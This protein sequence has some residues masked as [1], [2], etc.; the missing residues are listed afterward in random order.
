MSLALADGL[1]TTGPAGKSYQYVFNFV[2]LEPVKFTGKLQ[3]YHKESLQTPIPVP[4]LLTSTFADICPLSLPM[5]MHT[6]SQMQ[7]LLS[8]RTCSCLL[9]LL[10]R[11]L[12]RSYDTRSPT[13]RT[14]HGYTYPFSALCIFTT[15]LPHSS[16]LLGYLNLF[17]KIKARK[18]REVQARVLRHFGHVRL[19]AALWTVYSPPGSPVHETLQARTLERVAMPSSRDLLDPGIFL[20]C[21]KILHPLSHLPKKG[22]APFKEPYEVSYWLICCISALQRRGFNIHFRRVSY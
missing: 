10:S 9:P 3:A 17:K 22:R 21:R 4:R 13:P 18:R 7:T 6:S 15:P 12:T 11:W 1:F 19:F 16:C 20:H 14:L 2:I 5:S 8:G